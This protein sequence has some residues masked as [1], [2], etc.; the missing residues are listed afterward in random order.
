[1]FW[2]LMEKF[3]HEERGLVLKFATGR[4]RY[5]LLCV[6]TVCL[7][8]LLV[9]LRAST[10]LILRGMLQASGQVANLLELL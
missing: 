5:A 7:G 8:V 6:D 4:I 10:G 2:E 1:M 9:V 3:S